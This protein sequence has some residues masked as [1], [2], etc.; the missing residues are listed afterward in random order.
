MSSSC[1]IEW[2]TFIEASYTNKMHTWEK[3]AVATFEVSWVVS[4]V[5][6]EYKD[7]KQTPR[8]FL[9]KRCSENMQQSYRRTPMPK[10]DFNKVVLQL[11]WNC[12]SSWCSPVNLQHI[13]R[14]PFP[15]NTS[16]QLLLKDIV[17]FELYESSYNISIEERS[18]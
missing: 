4:S 10:C 17:D 18:K 11:Y 5:H 15:N 1:H 16:G 7:Q 3:V 13:F 9:R 8:G 2:K 14:T 6:G 12:T